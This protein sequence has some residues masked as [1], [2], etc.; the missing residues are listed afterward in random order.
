MPTHTNSNN[1]HLVNFNSQALIEMIFS[2]NITFKYLKLF[3]L[4]ENQIET[5][6]Q[7]LKRK[8]KKMSSS[9]L[10]RHYSIKYG[11]KKK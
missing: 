8:E 4:E 2:H 6:T 7:N 3:K 1:I 9:S 5:F 11:V 10:K